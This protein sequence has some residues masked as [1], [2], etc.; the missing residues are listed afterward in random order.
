MNRW[1]MGWTSGCVLDG[2]MGPPVSVVAV[3][4]GKSRRPQHTV[5]DALVAGAA[6]DVAG[7]GVAD[8]RFGGGR[9]FRQQGGDLHEEAAREEASLEGVGFAHGFL[10]WTHGPVGGQSLYRRYR[11]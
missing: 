4:D 9:C 11:G 5:E 7:Q 10:Q 6:A 8:L 1:A 3:G 2:G